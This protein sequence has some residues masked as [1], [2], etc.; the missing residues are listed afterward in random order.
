MGY[1]YLHILISNI[2]VSNTANMKYYKP[3]Y[4]CGSHLRF[5]IHVHTKINKETPIRLY[6]AFR[7]CILEI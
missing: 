6:E 3:V 1:K 4:K 7:F 5:E 2:L